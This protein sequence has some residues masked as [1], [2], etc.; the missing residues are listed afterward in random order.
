[1]FR[2]SSFISYTD[3]VF[4]FDISSDGAVVV[5]ASDSHVTAHNTDS[6]VMLWQ[7]NMPEFTWAVRVHGGQVVASSDGELTSILELTTGHCTLS[8]PSP[9]REVL[10]ILVYEGLCADHNC[11]NNRNNKILFGVHK[12]ASEL[13]H[14]F[15][16]FLLLPVFFSNR[17]SSQTHTLDRILPYL[18]LL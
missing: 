13:I 3:D 5:G 12:I 16:F 18:C 7:R 9:G 1:M 15:I 8:L 4:S 14:I 17:F 6:G 11:N 2:F 10:A